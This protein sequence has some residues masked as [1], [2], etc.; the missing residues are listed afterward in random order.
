MSW[1]CQ[2]RIAD[3]GPRLP[4]VP[5][6]LPSQVGNDIFDKAAANSRQRQK[7][8]DFQKRELDLFDEE[9]EGNGSGN[10]NNNNNNN[11]AS[12]SKRSRRH[13]RGRGRGRGSGPAAPANKKAGAAVDAERLKA[14]AITAA[15]DARGGSGNN[16]KTSGFQGQLVDPNQPNRKVCGAL[17]QN[18]KRPI[19]SHCGG[20]VVDSVSNRSRRCIYVTTTPPTNA[21][22]H[23]GSLPRHQEGPLSPLGVTVQ[24][25]PRELVLALRAH[26]ALPRGEGKVPT[27]S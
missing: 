16:N 3:A 12:A 22:I 19:Q 8:L 18:E 14:A 1:A 24:Q 23:L 15:R 11:N 4:P 21:E 27:D 5:M 9:P 2:V 17:I 13:G 20:R 6:I 25:G 26:P 7:A 10:G